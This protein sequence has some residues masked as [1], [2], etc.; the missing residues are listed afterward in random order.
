MDHL[1]PQGAVCFSASPGLSSQMTIDPAFSPSGSQLGVQD[2]P[3]AT[4]LHHGQMEGTAQS[5]L[6][7][8]GHNASTRE[9]SRRRVSEQRIKEKRR[10]DKERKKK[11]RVNGKQ[12]YERICQLLGI[13]LMPENDRA[14]RSECLYIHPIWSVEHFTVLEV[15]EQQQEVINDLRR[16]LEENEEYIETLKKSRTNAPTG[17]YIGTSFPPHQGSPSAG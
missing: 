10:K 16:Q 7:A 3:C 14:Q 6:V 8:Q 9:A 2:D 17:A 1:G 4:L 12:A 11:Y 13:D 15:V 5:Y